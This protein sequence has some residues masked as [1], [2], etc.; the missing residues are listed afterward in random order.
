[1]NLRT[2]MDDRGKL[3]LDL[4]VHS[5]IQAQALRGVVTREE[6]DLLAL[7]QRRVELP[8]LKGGTHAFEQSFAKRLAAR[9]TVEGIDMAD[10]RVL[11]ELRKKV[12]S[13]ATSRAGDENRLLLRNGTSAYGYAGRC[14]V[15]AVPGHHS[16]H[17]V[18]L[19]LH[20]CFGIWLEIATGDEGVDEVA[21]GVDGWILVYNGLRYLPLDVDIGRG[22]GRRCAQAANDVVADGC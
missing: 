18:S 9:C 15:S 21:Q 4:R 6:S 3:A 1:M 22:C 19:L 13:E 10:L 12:A 5:R 11:D 7:K 8:R 16:L 14:D 2:V 20:D 17:S